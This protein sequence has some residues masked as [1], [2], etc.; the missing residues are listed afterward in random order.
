[1]QLWIELI[2]CLLVSFWRLASPQVILKTRPI[3]GI[4]HSQP[5][6]KLA[7]GG[8]PYVE[9]PYWWNTIGKD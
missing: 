4:F 8:S 3:G 1:M 5:K 7:I 9:G 2:E 6:W